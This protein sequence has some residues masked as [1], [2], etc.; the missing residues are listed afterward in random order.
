MHCSP[1][2]RNRRVSLPHNSWPIWQ[3]AVLLAI[4]SQS[5][6]D[7]SP[8]P[9]A[10]HWVATLAAATVDWFSAATHHR[11]RWARWA[12]PAA[13]CRVAP[14]PVVMVLPAWGAIACPAML[15]PPV[16]CCSSWVMATSWLWQTFHSSNSNNSSCNKQCRSSSSSN[17]I[18]RSNSC[19]KW[20][21]AHKVQHQP[22]QQQVTATTV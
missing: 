22:Q 19:S 11:S 4:T 17:S 15:H 1:T 8:P 5:R 18:R 10:V 21:S 2:I 14:V 9:T 13:T 7:A 3:Q 6:A 16:T 20:T 12:P